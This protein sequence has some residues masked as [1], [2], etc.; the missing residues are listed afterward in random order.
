CGILDGIFRVLIEF[1]AMDWL[2]DAGLLEELLTM[3]AMKEVRQGPALQPAG[4]CWASLQPAGVCWA[5][6]QPSHNFWG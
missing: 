5:S 4:V 3:H 1:C 2:A 6:L